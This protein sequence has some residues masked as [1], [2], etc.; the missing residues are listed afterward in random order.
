MRS[1]LIETFK[2]DRNGKYDINTELFFQLD[3]GGRMGQDMTRN[4]YKRFKLDV[5]IIGICSLPVSSTVALLPL[6]RNTCRLN[7]NWKL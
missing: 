3:E 5:R 7:W 2:H 1:D 4:C 6:S